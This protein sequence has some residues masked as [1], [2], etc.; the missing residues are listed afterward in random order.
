MPSSAPN[1][2]LRRRIEIMI[3][4][5]SPLLDVALLVGDRVSRALERD[6]P[7]YVPPRMSHR[8]ESP[9]RGIHVQ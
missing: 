4:L 8:G 9:P 7:D 1:P 3:R 5:M 2:V 6:D